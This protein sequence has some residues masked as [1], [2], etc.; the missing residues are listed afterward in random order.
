MSPL[1]ALL[2]FI[3][4]IISIAILSGLAYSVYLQGDKV[5]VSIIV[6]VIVAFC[7]LGFTGLSNMTPH[8]ETFYIESVGDF[9]QI[10]GQFILG[11]GVINGEDVYKFYIKESRGSL[12]R[13]SVESDRA[14]LFFDEDVNPYI[15]VH[16]GSSDYR[17]VEIHIPSDAKQL[18]YNIDNE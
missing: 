10:E 12:I 5:L 8:D 17:C 3:V 9:S 11:T 15:L 2:F 16:C 1:E 4:D 7:A 13:D 6:M 18:E 14:R